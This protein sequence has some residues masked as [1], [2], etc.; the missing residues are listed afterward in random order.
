MSSN[1][2]I[3]DTAAYKN[4]LLE[5]VNST[6]YMLFKGAVMFCVDCNGAPPQEL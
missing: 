5:N 1:R 6:N 2:L 3:Y 4:K